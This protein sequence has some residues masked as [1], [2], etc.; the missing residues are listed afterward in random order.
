MSVA[1]VSGSP[2]LPLLSTQAEGLTSSGSTQTSSTATGLGSDP[3]Y[4]LSLGQQQAESA[5]LGYN[6][7]GQLVNQAGQ[8]LSQ[9][10]QTDPFLTIDASNDAP[11]PTQYAVDVQQLA[12][13]Q[14]LMSAE[15]P[16]ADQTVVGTGALTIQLGAYDAATNS[17]TANGSPVVV[18]VQDGTLNGI[19][20]A[21]NEANAGVTASVV[22]SSDGNDRLVIAG[23]DTG[24]ANAFTVGGI[25]ALSYDPTT[26]STGGLEMTATAQDAAYTVNGIAQTYPS[27]QNVPI[28][29]GVVS[30]L[31]AQGTMTV[32]A[33]FGQQQA[34]AAAS[35]LAS[36]FNSL[37]QSIDQSIGSGGELNADSS[38]ASGLAEALS[39]ITTTTF[40]GGK[41][42]ADIGIT[43][44][45]D[46]TLTVDAQTLQSA[47]ASDP[48][49]TNA[50]IAQASAAMQQAIGGFE[51]PDGNIESQT[52]ALAAIMCRGPSLADFLSAESSSTSTASPFSILDPTS[53]LSG[54]SALGQNT[55]GQTNSGQLTAAAVLALAQSDP[56]LANA[57]SA[58]A[59]TPVA[60]TSPLPVPGPTS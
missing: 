27:N 59:G 41:S 24:A 46:G 44:Q 39:A 20:S 36:A 56:S 50:V 32:S 58:D 5:L 43:T 47:Y 26:A 10:N 8:T 48:A 28:A 14:S 38:V 2:L 12:Q 22:Q 45:S 18:D 49:G 54:Q 57:L 55:S 37:V 9:L 53:L 60:P 11:P 1:G 33:P 16:D 31:T 52:R 42:L 40:G 3:A 7:L 34:A 23:N 19:A 25:P 17:F 51:G 13:A 21:I 4:L 30:N 6:Q 35:G 15:Y 29:P